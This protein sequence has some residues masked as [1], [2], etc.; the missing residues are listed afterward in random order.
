MSCQQPTA[1]A[2]GEMSAP[3]PKGDLVAHYSILC[4]SQAGF[5]SIVKYF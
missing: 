3:V 2:A 4:I 5:L 1:P